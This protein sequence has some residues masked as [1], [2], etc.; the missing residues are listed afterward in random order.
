MPSQNNPQDPTVLRDALTREVTN[1][2]YN[3]AGQIFKGPQGDVSRVS[4]DQLDER[5]RQAFTNND[6][7]YLMQEA[8]R[9]PAQFL[10]AV[11]RL[12]VTMP[13]GEEI[14][15]DPPLPSAAKSNAPIPKPPEGVQPTTFD[16]PSNVPPPPALPAP[17]MPPGPVAAPPPMAMPQSAPMA[18]AP[19]APAPPPMMPP[20]VILGPNGQPLPPSVPA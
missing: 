3:I 4:N 20:P 14:Q 11:E 18:P 10:A 17:P 16:Q 7:G 19:M 1:D 15:K 8:A 5:Y 13:P 2:A 6:R 12:G 9:D